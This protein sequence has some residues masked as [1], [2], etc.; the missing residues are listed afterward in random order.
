MTAARAV[1]RLLHVGIPADEP[2]LSR[3]SE[4]V[5]DEYHA[6]VRLRMGGNDEEQRAYECGEGAAKI[7]CLNHRVILREDSSGC[8]S[9]HHYVAEYRRR[10]TLLCLRHRVFPPELLPR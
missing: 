3:F 1:D 4:V 6:A 7:P 5:A 2:A 9:Q 8:S 10:Q